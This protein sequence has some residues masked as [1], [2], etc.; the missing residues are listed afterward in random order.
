MGGSELPQFKHYQLEISMWLTH[1]SMTSCN[2]TIYHYF[3]IQFFQIVIVVKRPEQKK[4]KDQT[5]VFCLFILPP[6]YPLFS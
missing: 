4:V 6:F 2:L 1:D 3:V 5:V